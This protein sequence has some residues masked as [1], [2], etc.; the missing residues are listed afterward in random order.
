MPDAEAI[1]C[2]TSEGW[3]DMGE[4][5]VVADSELVKTADDDDGCE[6]SDRAAKSG[7]VWPVTS[8]DS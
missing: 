2:S 6:L 4:T 7:S 8:A 1:G 5:P 3:L